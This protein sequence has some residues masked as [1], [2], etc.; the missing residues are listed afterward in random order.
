M[1]CAATRH[2]QGDRCADDGVVIGIFE[3]YR[4]RRSDGGTGRSASVGCCKN[5]IV[6]AAPAVF[7]RLNT[8]GV[9]NPDTAAL[10]AYEPRLVFAVALT[11]ACPLASVVT[12]I[13]GRKRGRCSRSGSRKSHLDSGQRSTGGVLHDCHQMLAERGVD[14]SAL[15]GTAEDLNRCGLTEVIYDANHVGTGLRNVDPP[16]RVDRRR[17]RAESLAASAG[18]PSPL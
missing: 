17:L 5:W 9:A 16:A 10:T 1:E 15:T 13:P 12:T 18:P 14:R 6:A 11:L 7:V 4:Y 2:G 3:T 8:A